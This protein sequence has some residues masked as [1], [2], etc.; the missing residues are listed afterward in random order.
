MIIDIYKDFTATELHKFA[1]ESPFQYRNMCK[2][3]GKFALGVRHLYLGVTLP[4]SGDKGC[5]NVC[6]VKDEI[7]E[8]IDTRYF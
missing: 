6:V 5:I 2:I 4:F 7:T 1:E 3:I 8:V